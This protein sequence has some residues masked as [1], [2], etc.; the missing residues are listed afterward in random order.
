VTS[1]ETPRCRICG[2]SAVPSAVLCPACSARLAGPTDSTATSA[3]N[4]VAPAP[5]PLPAAFPASLPAPPPAP[6]PRHP[7]HDDDLPWG[8]R[9]DQALVLVVLLFGGLL[10]IMLLGPPDRR[11]L[12]DEWRWSCAKA[13]LEWRVTTQARWPPP[14]GVDA[15]F[16]NESASTYDSLA[17][18][19]L[20]EL[21]VRNPALRVFGPSGAPSARA[22]EGRPAAA[23]EQPAFWITLRESALLLS[24]EVHYGGDASKNVAP[25]AFAATEDGWLIYGPRLLQLAFVVGAAGALRAFARGRSYRRREREYHETVR[26]FVQRTGRA[27]AELE[28]AQSLARDGDVARALLALSETLRLEPSYP[29]ALRLRDELNASGPVPS[30]RRPVN[31]LSLRI[32][33][34]PYAY[35][36][37]LDATTLTVGR[38]R[39]EVNRNADTGNDFVVRVPGDTFRSLFISRRHFE[40]ERIGLHYFII[41]RSKKGIT[42]N[43]RRLPAGERAPIA[44][45]D[46]LVVADVVIVEVALRPALHPGHRQRSVTLGGD[47][48]LRGVVLEASV[49]D[50][51]TL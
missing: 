30:E 46:R 37:P 5:E 8:R 18:G 19:L 20:S 31:V 2:T 21:G 51:V 22:S 12:F 3:G 32:V 11:P 25:F 49:G 9:F 13:N 33:G 27:R 17:L 50:M 40:I 41:D 29:E 15:F 4:P 45:G 43:G 44:S 36:A 39:R 24:L 28:R 35:E 10:N 16:L 42:L 1:A 7:S 26:A 48:R 38:Q 23:P 6:L 47:A 14:E 34:T